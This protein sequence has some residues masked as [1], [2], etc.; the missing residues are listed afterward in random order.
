[1][2][3]WTK[4]QKQAIDEEG[5]D[6]LVSA[7]AGSG[8]TE[9]LSERAL[10]KV[11][12][13]TNI[14]A[15]LILTFTKAAAYEMK[16]RIRNKI[17]KAGLSEQVNRIE[18]AYITTFDSFSLAMV[19]KYHDRLKITKDV[20]IVEENVISLKKQE[21]LEEIL[22]D[23]YHHP[24]SSFENLI[25]HFCL[26]DDRELKKLVIELSNKLDLK[27]DKKTYLEN[28][29][30]QYFS[31]EYEEQTKKEY[32]SLCLEE[33]QEIRKNLKTLEL[34]LEGKDYQK[35]ADVFSPILAATNY[36]ALKKSFV[37]DFPRLPNH[38]GEEVKQA[39]EGI[40][41]KIEQ[42]KSYT[43]YETEDEM[44]TDYL[45]TKEDLSVIIEIIQKLDQR[46]DAYKREKNCFEFIDIAKLAITAVKE[47]PDI[48]TEIK[49]TFQEIMIDEYQDTSDLQ[50]ELIQAISDHNT[51]MVGDIKQSIYRFRNANPQ[52]FKEKY[53]RFQN[54]QGGIKIDLNKNFRSREEVLTNINEIF[55]N[56]MDQA[57]GGADYPHGHQ[58]IFGNQAYQEEGKTNFSNQMELYTYQVEKDS[59][60]QKY[61]NDEIE[62]FFIASDIQKKKKEKYQVYDKTLKKLRDVTYGDFVILIDRSSKFNLYKKIFEYLNVP[63]T[64]V[65]DENIM[66]Q[67]EVYLIRNI[68]RLMEC[69]EAK[70]EGNRFR[71]SFTSIARSYLFSYSDQ[72]IF[73]ILQKKSFLETEI[74][75]KIHSLVQDSNRMD[76][77][78]LLSRIKEEFAFDQKL[79]QVGNIEMGIA[80]LEYFLSLAQNLQKLGYDYH[81]FLVYLDYMIDNQKEMKIPV[82]VLEENS[83][84]LMTIH[85]SKGLE[86]PI[87]YYSGLSNP[88]NIKEI[89][90]KILFDSQYGIILPSFQEGYHDTYIKILAKRKYELEEI[91]EKIRLFYV[92]LTRCKEKMIFLLN[93]PLEDRMDLEDGVVRKVERESYHS[94][95]DIL[96]SIGEK[97]VGKTIPISLDQVPLT[98]QYKMLSSRKIR[99]DGSSD[100]LSISEY[101]I[102]ERVVEKTTFSKEVHTLL[103]PETVKEMEFGTRMHALF[104]AIDFKHPEFE[105]LNLSFFERSLMVAFL[106]QPFLKNIKEANII[107]EYEFYDP[108]TEKDGVID[109]I[110]EYS[111]HIDIIDYK[112]KNVDDI[113]YIKQLKGYQN[114]LSQKTK[115][116]ISIYLYSILNQKFQQIEVNSF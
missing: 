25:Q 64:I 109:L 45:S 77:Y 85:K 83:C 104:E 50:E 114:Y 66:N 80:V 22:E 27:Y 74:I 24:T 53:E 61:T 39:K 92:A 9:I 3:N 75:Q 21:L 37:F 111:D 88:F 70:E 102:E 13:K 54:Q 69:V 11:L 19:K 41:E 116:K 20:S 112:L 76:L 29:I 30:I 65:K 51:Y 56:V 55:E 73:T 98:N 5:C 57:I 40:K 34:A 48:L 94:F 47:N 103:D 99:P 72:E 100:L 86:Y 49:A 78:T 105:T 26:K 97:I 59:P 106:Q 79:I 107:K 28:Y 62:A 31:S 14:D 42:L 36:D 91:G 2:P 81:R 44:F 35:F 96:K 82:S 58:M 4:E 113:S 115:K 33:I 32:F 67:K 38:S 71:Y 46:I 95:F 6:I 16:N 93:Q 10:R 101:Q 12:E 84:R 87:C 23:Y 1:M 60:Y 90:S 18:K 108:E 110:L 89:Q 43:M 15:I 63:L 17:Q 52:I 68:L 8:K 7:G